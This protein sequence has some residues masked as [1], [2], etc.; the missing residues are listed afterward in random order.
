MA[1]INLTELRARKNGIG[2]GGIKNT[3]DVNG[4]NAFTNLPL[5]Y[6]NQV[7]DAISAGVVGPHSSISSTMYEQSMWPRYYDDVTND[8]YFDP[9][10]EM[11][12]ENPKLLS[13]QIKS[14]EEIRDL[15]TWAQFERILDSLPKYGESN[16]N[17]SSAMQ[18]VTPEQYRQV[19]SYIARNKGR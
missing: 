17:F 13:E 18:G 10:T 1:E 11:E 7:P 8:T 6:K 3:S 5:S 4:N 9:V 14:Q 15:L 12:L 16:E 2:L 19:L